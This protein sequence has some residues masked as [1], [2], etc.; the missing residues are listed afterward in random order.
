MEFLTRL[1]YPG[2]IRQLKNMVE[3][4][5]LIGGPRLVKD[6]F[7]TL[8]DMREEGRVMQPSGTLDDK[9]KEAIQQALE[10]AEGNLTQASRILGITRQTLYRRMEKHGI[11]RQ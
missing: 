7:A 10:Q 3:R 1:H 5:V 4:A 2:N 6:D 9:E 8:A 11:N